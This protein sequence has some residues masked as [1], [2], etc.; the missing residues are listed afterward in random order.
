MRSMMPHSH[1]DNDQQIF[2]EVPA[3]LEEYDDDGCL[4]R[5]RFTWLY[6]GPSLRG[7]AMVP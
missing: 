1:L 7:P 3:S 6:S 4:W 5:P 2:S